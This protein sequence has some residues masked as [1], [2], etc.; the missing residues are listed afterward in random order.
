VGTS[1]KAT[2]VLLVT[3][4]VVAVL[5]STIARDRRSE[6]YR[7]RRGDLTGW[8]LVS[9]HGSEPWVVALQPPARLAESLRR[10]V[11]AKAGPSFHLPDHAAIPLV[12][13]TE[14]ADSLQGERDVDSILKMA[15]ADG[16]QKTIFQP[17]CVGQRRDPKGSSSEMLFVV[18]DAPG[19]WQ[20]RGNLIPDH[21]EIAGNGVYDPAA[22]SPILPLALTDDD[23]ERWLPLRVNPLTDCQA[24]LVIE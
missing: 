1:A 20:L 3:S 2:I 10:Q 4:S 11:V 7:I 24:S 16:I 8:T 5:V 17:T 9:S 14:Y 23:V 6:P 13:R 15:D 18:F 21:Q 12:L 22:L 19:F